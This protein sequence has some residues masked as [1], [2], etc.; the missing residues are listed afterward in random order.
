MQ[1]NG[2]EETKGG[3]FSYQQQYGFGR[4]SVEEASRPETMM[5]VS[6]DKAKQSRGGKRKAGKEYIKNVF[7]I[8]TSYCRT[9][10]ELI[11]HVIAKCGFME[12]TAGGSLYWFGLSLQDK[13][14]KHVAKKKCF[15]NRY[16]GLDYLCRKKVFCDINNRMRRTF[17]KLFNFSPISFLVPEEGQALQDY[18]QL[19]PKFT[20]IGKPSR[21][22][23]GEGIILIQKFSDIPKNI[24]SYEEK[25]MLV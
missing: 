21:G 19:H 2:Y 20:F 4:D 18:M 23:G 3:T 9:E 5:S 1:Q 11:Q 22:R 17:P 10:I 15:Y 24:F 12:T 7:S 8:N 14:I 6:P 13:D 16:P 25:D